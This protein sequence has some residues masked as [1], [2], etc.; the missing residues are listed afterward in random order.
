MLSTAIV[1][2]VATAHEKE[3]TV[4]LRAVSMTDSTL[5]FTSQLKD[6]KFITALAVTEVRVFSKRC[7][8]A[9][10]AIT[11]NVSPQETKEVLWCKWDPVKQV[12]ELLDKPKPAKDQNG[13]FTLKEQVTCPGYY[14]YFIR[15]Q[16][17]PKG[18][19]VRVPSRYRINWLFLEQDYPMAFRS[20]VQPRTPEREC[21]L[22][23]G[24]IRFDTVVRMQVTDKSGEVHTM[25]RVLAGRFLDFMEEPDAAGYRVMEIP[26]SAFEQSGQP[27][28]IKTN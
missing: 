20:S 18:I 6:G 12:W 13:H 24:D 16:G 15:P 11:Y 22:T 21:V 10:V 23:V 14:G 19:R 3:D 1:V 25:E 28:T 8:P 7:L 5:A 26:A 17:I 9:P 27:L 4:E 2:M